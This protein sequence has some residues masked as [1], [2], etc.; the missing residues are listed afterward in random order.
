MRSPTV[1]QRTRAL[2]VPVQKGT[3]SPRLLAETLH[4]L[5]SI[6]FRYDDEKSTAILQQPIKKKGFDG[7]RLAIIHDLTR[8]RP[9]RT[10]FGR[11]VYWQTSESNS[12][13]IAMLALLISIIVGVLSLGLS[14]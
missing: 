1:W 3:L 12:F 10:S 5:Q 9:P 6:L 14:G 7:G 8:E 2:Q 4:S 11:W 13:L